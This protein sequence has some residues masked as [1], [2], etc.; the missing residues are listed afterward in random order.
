MISTTSRLRT[1]LVVIVSATAGI[2]VIGC[3]SDTTTPKPALGSHERPLVARSTEPDE[4]VASAAGE[5][6][7][8]P[9]SGKPMKTKGT[10]TPR[11]IQPRHTSESAVPRHNR[12][13]MPG[14]NYAQL[15]ANRSPEPTSSSGS[16]SR[17]GPC[18]LVTATEAASILGSPMQEPIEAAQGPT[19]LYRT[20][21][22]KRLVTLA[23]QAGSFGQIKLKI[24]HPRQLD[25]AGH[26]ATCGVYGQPML[27]V[28]LTGRRVLSISA[29]CT[30]A[31]EFA[32]KALGRL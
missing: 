19:C 16:R 22:G 26:A 31:E 30:T 1:L 29:S 8:V 2:T 24:H 18:T 5:G 20:R 15:H 14:P 10:L 27:Y 32:L 4:F 12:N 9:T 3:G 13:G 28:P 11:P 7:A 21:S 6:A 25:I 17:S 23:V